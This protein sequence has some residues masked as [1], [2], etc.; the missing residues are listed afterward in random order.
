[1]VTKSSVTSGQS[2]IDALRALVDQLWNDLW[3][4]E[5]GAG[6]PVIDVGEVY[7]RLGN[8]LRRTKLTFSAFLESTP[9]QVMRLQAQR[10]VNLSAHALKGLLLDVGATEP[11]RLA[12][13]I[14]DADSTS[15]LATMIPD[16][17]KQI[18]VVSEFVS[19]IL[20]RLK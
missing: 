7:D 12:Q 3:S 16:L 19:K 14:E 1:M 18:G 10:D 20:E 2:E 11:A 5:L 15:Q 8:S 4:D 13:E 9:E 17:L 6:P